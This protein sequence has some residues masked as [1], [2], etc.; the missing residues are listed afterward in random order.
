MEKI[1]PERIEQ[2]AAERGMRINALC[3]LADVNRSIFTRWKNG[4]TSPTVE[5]VNRLIAA[6]QPD[7]PPD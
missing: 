6:A 7:V 3:R 5:T 4:S 1:T 2:L